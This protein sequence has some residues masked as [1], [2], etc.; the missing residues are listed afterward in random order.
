MVEIDKSIPE[1]EEMTKEE[2]ISQLSEQIRLIETKLGI[3]NKAQ[4]LYKKLLKIKKENYQIVGDKPKYM[5]MDEF[6][7]TQIEYEEVMYDLEQQNSAHLIER[8]KMMLEQLNKRLK[9]VEENEWRTKKRQ[10]GS[11]RSSTSRT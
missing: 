4:E 9:E 11:T 2:K 6:V 8:E 5:T 3:L 1:N 10:C 7:K